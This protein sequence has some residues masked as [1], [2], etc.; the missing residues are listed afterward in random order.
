[1]PVRY[2]PDCD[3]YDVLGLSPECD[4]GTLEA[5]Y[6][7]LATRYHPDASGSDTGDRM[8]EI[9]VAHDALRDASRRGQ[10]DRARWAYCEPA[11]RDTFPSARTAIPGPLGRGPRA[12]RFVAVHVSAFLLLSLLASMTG[13]DLVLTYHP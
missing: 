10:Y 3:A 6:R 13:L 9:N 2:D 4:S 7:H 5:V 1:M 8:A 11:T 12:A